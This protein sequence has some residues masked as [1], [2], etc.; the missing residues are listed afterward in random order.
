MRLSGRAIEPRPRSN[1]R[2]ERRAGN[3]SRRGRSASHF[4]NH[5]YKVNE[6]RRA[7]S[8]HKTTQSAAASIMLD[9]RGEVV[10]NHGFWGPRNPEYSENRLTGARYVIAAWA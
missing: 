2:P 1:L 3:C 8:A 5:D 10:G 7:A 9:I 4:R 6:P